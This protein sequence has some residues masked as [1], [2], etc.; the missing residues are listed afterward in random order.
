MNRKSFPTSSFP[1]GFSARFPACITRSLPHCD[2]PASVSSFGFRRGLR[3]LMAVLGLGTGAGLTFAQYDGA[4]TVFQHANVIDGY[5][6]APLR[7]V[8]VSIAGGKIV[9]IDPAGKQPPAGARVIDLKG[10]WLLPGF[11]DAH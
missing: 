1:E 5:S 9:G 10:K 8:L 7:D 6:E 3:T 2:Q 11:V 4:T